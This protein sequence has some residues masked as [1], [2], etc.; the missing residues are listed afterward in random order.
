L[1]SAPD[2]SKGAEGLRTQLRNKDSEN[3][4][5]NEHVIYLQEQLEEFMEENKLLRDMAKAPENF[6]K[7]RENVRMHNKDKIDDY[8]KLV[9][10]LQDDN[11]RLEEERAK[12][13]H[14]LK[15]VHLLPKQF[16]DLDSLTVY[17]MEDLG[18]KLALNTKDDLNKLQ[19]CIT[20]I[21]VGEDPAG[22]DLYKAKEANNKHM[23][24]IRF[25]EERAFDEIKV[26]METILQNMA[27]SGSL[28]GGMSA[29]QIVQMNSNYDDLRG[30]LE[31][32]LGNMQADPH[33]STQTGF[34]RM[35][36]LQPPKPEKDAIKGTINAGHSFKFDSQFAIT[37]RMDLGADNPV[38]Y[39]N[40][41]LQLQL[42]ECFALNEKQEL[43]I[44]KQKREIDSIHQ[45]MK[46][47]LLMQDHMYKDYVALEKKHSEAEKLML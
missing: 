43:I 33:G 47:Y 30:K 32:L 20:R 27:K 1:N 34:Q 29:D 15:R 11:Y 36:Q 22:S 19:E 35:G 40:A 39:D 10:V 45:K 14:Q 41:F 6:G 16:G 8:K 38:T 18:E 5:L 26:H 7:N 2:L 24:K 42:M 13:K 31:N 23:Q 46:R 44:K 25:L 4:K 3:Q 21:A 17:K 28:G 9:R 12:L 37:P